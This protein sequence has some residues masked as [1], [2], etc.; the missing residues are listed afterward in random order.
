MADFKCKCIHAQ[1]R[2]KWCHP[3]QTEEGFVVVQMEKRGEKAESSHEQQS[4]YIKIY[5]LIYNIYLYYISVY[6]IYKLYIF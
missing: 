2:T 5:L 4:R 1:V 3:S 6:I